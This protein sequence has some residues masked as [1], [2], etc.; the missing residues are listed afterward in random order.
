MTFE[1]F[2][3]QFTPHIE[4]TASND[5]DAHESADDGAEEVKKSSGKPGTASKKGTDNGM[6]RTSSHYVGGDNDSVENDK[7]SVLSKNTKKSGMNQSKFGSI[8]QLNQTDTNFKYEIPPTCMVSMMKKVLIE[9]MTGKFFLASHPVPKIEGEMIIFKPKK[10]DQ[11][12]G[13]DVIVYRDFSL[14]KRVETV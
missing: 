14:R 4:G 1:D 13:K 2:L 8:S 9:K 3:E 7:R 6:N 10:S 11:T 12:Q 5:R